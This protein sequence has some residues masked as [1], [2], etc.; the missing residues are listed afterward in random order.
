MSEALQVRKWVEGYQAIVSYGAQYGAQLEEPVKTEVAKMFWRTEVFPT[1][2]E[3]GVHR[4]CKEADAS[5]WATRLVLRGEPLKSMLA[6][7]FVS[8]EEALSYGLGL[9]QKL[10]FEN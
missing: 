7:A 3:N 5:F 1:K 2:T 9:T 6:G 8:A 10:G 4:V